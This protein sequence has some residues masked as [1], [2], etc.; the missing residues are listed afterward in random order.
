MTRL[1]SLLLTC[2]LATGTARQRLTDGRERGDIPGW[3]MIA[4]MSAA[5]VVV[6]IPLVGPAIAHAFTNAIDNVS[7]TPSSGG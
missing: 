2:W 3:V 6:L 7:N 5:V 4:I 1:Q